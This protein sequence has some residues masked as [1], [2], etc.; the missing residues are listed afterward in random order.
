MLRVNYPLHIT[1][2][3][4]TYI[5]TSVLPKSITA[6]LNGNGWKLLGKSFYVTTK[7]VQYHIA[8]PLQVSNINTNLLIAQM[9]EQI[10]DVVVR[11]VVHDTSS[12]TFDRR[13]QKKVVLKLDSTQ[14]SLENNFVVASLINLA[15]NVVIFDG[16]ASAMKQL[17]DTIWVKIAAKR[18]RTNFD[19]EVRIDIPRSPLMKA[20]TEKVFVSFEVA[21]LL[22]N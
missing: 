8:A 2:N 1:Y 15:P 10:K 17:K 12:F 11:G 21:E 14:I 18:L 7:P 5:P 19:E 3:D 13:I 9:Q 22:S 6:L 16:A 4:T 20:N